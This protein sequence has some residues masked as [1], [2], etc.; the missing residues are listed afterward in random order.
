[1]L[2]SGIAGQR[3]SIKGVVVDTSGQ[4]MPGTTVVLMTQKDSLLK[5][6]TSSDADGLYRLENI[7]KGKYI[8]QA[9]FT[10]YT[11]YEKLLD[12]QGDNKEIIMD[13]IVLKP[14]SV[15]LE[16]IEISGEKIP[17]KYVN[18]TLIYDATSF[19]TDKNAVVEDLLK[20]MPGIEVDDNGKIKA[21]GKEVKK[22]TVDGKE[23]FGNDP[24]MATKNLPAEAV[25]KVK[26][27]D[28][29]S[30]YSEITDIDDG[31]EEKTIDLE[32]K[33]DHKSGIFGKITGGY[34]TEDKYLFK[35]NIN[36]FSSKSRITF[37]S[38]IN[39]TSK[40][41][42]SAN[43]M[44]TIA[45]GMQMLMDENN[46]ISFNP[47]F[48]D[49][50]QGISKVNNTGTNIIYFPVKNLDVIL[51]YYLKKKDNTTMENV[52]QKNYVQN[53][54][55][56]KYA[57]HDKSLNLTG[58]YLNAMIKYKINKSSEI[59]WK[60]FFNNNATTGTSADS[61]YTYNSGNILTNDFYGE[62][63]SDTK[64]K[65]I[66]TFLTYKNKF[67]KKGRALLAKFSADISGNIA[68]NYY[69][70]N[71]VYYLLDSNKIISQTHNDYTQKYTYNTKL[72]YTEPLTKKLSLVVDY[73]QKNNLN[74]FNKYIKDN[75]SG[76][77]K[78]LYE[79]EFNNYGITGTLKYVN[80]KHK[81]S[82]GIKYQQSTLF[83]DYISN[84]EN[85]SKK[86]IDWL[87]VFNYIYKIKRSTTFSL[88]FHS[89]LVAPSIMDLMPIVNNSNPLNIFIG[90][91][92][93][94]P[95]KRYN[96]NINFFSFNMFDGT[97]SFAFLMGSLTQNSIIKSKTIDE[98]FKTITQPVNHGN[99]G[100]LFLNVT[101]N[102]KLKFLFDPSLS[103]SAVSS[104]NHGFTLINGIENESNRLNY[105]LEASLSHYKNSHLT[106]KAGVEYSITDIKYS[107]N[108]NQNQNYSNI[109][110]FTELKWKIS[111]NLIFKNSLKYKIYSNSF[112]SA[113][114][115]QILWNSYIKLYLNNKRFMIKLEAFDI[116]N[117]NKDFDQY[118]FNNYLQYSK[119]NTIG[120]YFMLSLTYS[121]SKFKAP[122]SPFS[123]KVVK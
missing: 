119:T 54:V 22:V 112:T 33:K 99:S 111:K 39:N 102:R 89:S 43:E 18:D 87:P 56:S 8:F 59:R 12:I 120:R 47:G 114:N 46:R 77:E 90:N 37:I 49:S 14:S 88:R 19:K 109:K 50:S 82:A 66:N 98:N 117:Q 74:T 57:G 20:K 30:D 95:E 32:L 65:T 1:M 78:D 101:H 108:K 58:H 38:K 29:K 24:K 7:K 68:G 75:F 28:K 70:S 76:Y 4:T 106:G 73:Y 107:I 45:G 23:F 81:L 103:I 35:T 110:Y 53:D 64:L 97:S 2:A 15:Q 17:V 104:Y 31:K 36:K 21:Q 86:Y 93:L 3:Y 123:I 27:F 79:S 9:S 80:S 85:I 105:S 42:F 55:F 13:T 84:K 41:G 11:K 121:L 113:D 100:H 16:T 118:A 61:S 72:A 116:L 94:E 62:T 91:K 92:D 10:S 48:F 69:N 51:S 60:F 63:N 6:F 83:G 5:Y 67:K 25:K 40:T 44:A 34:G 52:L 26:V 71:A 122:Q 115:T 96:L